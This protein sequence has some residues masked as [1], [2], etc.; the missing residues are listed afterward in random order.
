MILTPEQTALIRRIVSVAETGRPEPQY[1]VVGTLADRRDGKRQ[2]SYGRLQFAEHSTLRALLEAYKAEG[3]YLDFA[4]WLPQINDGTL[5]DNPEFHNLLT[6]A[7]ISDPAMKRAQD[8]FYDARYWQPARQW[9]AKHRFQLALSMLVIF[10]SFVQSGS[11]PMWLRVKFREMTPDW[12]G[13]EKQWIA[14]YA[15]TRHGWLRAHSNSAVRTSAY[16][17]ACYLEQITAG[18]WDLK[19]PVRMNG[20]DV[21]LV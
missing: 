12:G 13:N 18:N 11:V 21:W 19:P 3:G 6:T 10:D 2:V 4:P 9:A 16:R 14:A 5:A 8:A 7:G 1:H 15:G 17:T 20:V